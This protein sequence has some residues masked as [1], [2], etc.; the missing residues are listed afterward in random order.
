MATPLKA[1]WADLSIACSA[2]G[3]SAPGYSASMPQEAVWRI[4]V[5][6]SD[7]L[8]EDMV[9]D[10]T[11]A[12]QLSILLSP[13]RFEQM[14]TIKPLSKFYQIDVNDSCLLHLIHLLRLEMQHTQVLSQMYATSIVT[15][16]VLHAA[17]ITG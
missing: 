1:A 17:R 9:L 13:V 14:T 11:A 3:Y 12:N 10:A 15:V 8:A 6:V 5:Q 7:S 2:P 4:E 16:L